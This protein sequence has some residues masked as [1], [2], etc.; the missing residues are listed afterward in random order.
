MNLENVQYLQEKTHLAYVACTAC[1]I[2]KDA[3]FYHGN[4]L[5]NALAEIVI[6]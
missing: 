4:C 3:H 5:L 1:S 6:E 2:S